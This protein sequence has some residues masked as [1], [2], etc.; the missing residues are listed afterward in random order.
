MT[1]LQ[2][3]LAA[4]DGG[5][6]NQAAKIPILSAAAPTD[7]TDAGQSSGTACGYTACTENDRGFQMQDL[8]YR[9]W[10][11]I[12]PESSLE[13]GS[14]LQGSYSESGSVSSS[15]PKEQ[16]S[17][18]QLDHKHLIREQLKKDLVQILINDIKS[19]K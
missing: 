12:I 1:P 14:F 13:N 9:D 2:A 11:L 6:Q 16:P 19:F 8:P 3:A 7:A 18:L 4:A 5:L 10:S 15:R 17:T